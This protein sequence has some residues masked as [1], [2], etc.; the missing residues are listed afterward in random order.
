M[1]PTSYW[2]KKPLTIFSSF[3]TVYRALKSVKEPSIME[4]YP[5]FQICRTARFNID[6]YIPKPETFCQ[7]SG[8]MRLWFIIT[9]FIWEIS[10][11][12]TVLFTPGSYRDEWS[13]NRIWRPRTRWISR[14]SR[15]PVCFVSGKVKLLKSI[16]TDSVINITRAYTEIFS[17]ADTKKRQFLLTKDRYSLVQCLILKDKS[18]RLKILRKTLLELIFLV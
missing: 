6:W 15:T 10:Q 1:I 14:T 5:I 16:K 17:N 4:I 18:R 9:Y 7:L 2:S 8:E 12:F 11:F 13:S 3:K